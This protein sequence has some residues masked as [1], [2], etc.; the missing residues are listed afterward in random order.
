[1]ESLPPPIVLNVI[2]SPS[3]VGITLIILAASS[4]TLGFFMSEPSLPGAK[5]KFHCVARQAR[6]GRGARMNPRPTQRDRQAPQAAQ[7]NNSAA[8]RRRGACEGHDK[9]EHRVQLGALRLG[10]P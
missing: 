9:A 7:G 1:M 10:E 6:S 2:A 5:L 3:C 4:S 8:S